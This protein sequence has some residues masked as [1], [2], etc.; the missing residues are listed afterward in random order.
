MRVV[1]GEWEGKRVAYPLATLDFGD[2]CM[3]RLEFGQTK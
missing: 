1:I 2:E 3:S